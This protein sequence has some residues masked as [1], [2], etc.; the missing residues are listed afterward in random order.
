MPRRRGYCLYLTID[1]MLLKKGTTADLW[2][3]RLGTLAGGR[4][5]RN[6]C[7]GFRRRGPVKCGIGQCVASA[8]SL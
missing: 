7:V 1:T 4:C 3:V 5:R 8:W 2:Q 6:A